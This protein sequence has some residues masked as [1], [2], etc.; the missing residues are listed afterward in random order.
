[1]RCGAAVR[2]SITSNPFAL[3]LMYAC[4]VLR[5][6][7]IHSAPAANERKRTKII[8]HVFTVAR[9]VFNRTVFRR[10]FRLLRMTSLHIVLEQRPRH[11]KPQAYILC[12]HIYINISCIFMYVRT[13][14]YTSRRSAATHLAHA[15][16]A[17]SLPPGESVV[18]HDDL[19][20]KPSARSY[21]RADVISRRIS[22]LRGPPAKKPNVVTRA[23]VRDRI[24]KETH[25]RFHP[26]PPKKNDTF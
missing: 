10:A 3:L 12:Q 14:S 5:I 19:P 15:E 21:D 6:I 9:N 25:R 17:L 23:T 4:C 2:I 11:R 24:D 13:A 26:L 16:P 20:S 1:M 7:F 8:T 22:F 18:L